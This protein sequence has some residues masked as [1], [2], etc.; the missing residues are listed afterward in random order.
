MKIEATVK[1][2]K[3]YSF[4]INGESF[5]GFKVKSE[6]EGLKKLINGRDTI[7]A[8]F[9][10]GNIFEDLMTNFLEVDVEGNKK[11]IQ[12]IKASPD[13]IAALKADILKDTSPKTGR[14]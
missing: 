14:S 13:I 6:W 7:I 8:D 9:G 10:T 11:P 3:L 5:D 2:E 1:T 4:T 12:I